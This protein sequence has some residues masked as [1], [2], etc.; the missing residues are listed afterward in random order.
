MILYDT[1]LSIP[2]SSIRVC[3]LSLWE[4]PR[5]LVL[6]LWKS[7]INN[8]NPQAEVAETDRRKLLTVE[9]VDKQ[10]LSYVLAMAVFMCEQ[11]TTRRQLFHDLYTR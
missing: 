7:W 3:R 4:I 10:H 6:P 8:I 2:C 9:F 5:K 1:I 11:C